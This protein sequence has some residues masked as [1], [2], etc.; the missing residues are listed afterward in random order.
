MAANTFEGLKFDGCWLGAGW[1]RAEASWLN[2]SAE[3]SA[4]WLAITCPAWKLVFTAVFS[5]RADVDAVSTED[6]D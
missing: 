4:F 3:E 5:E 6:R 2:W 1:G